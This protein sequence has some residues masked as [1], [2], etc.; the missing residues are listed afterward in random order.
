MLTDVK[1]T[2]IKIMTIVNVNLILTTDIG[3]CYY[4]VVYGL[5]AFVTDVVIT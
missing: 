2:C 1:S 5:N 4:H 3:K